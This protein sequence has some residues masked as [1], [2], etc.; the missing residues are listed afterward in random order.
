M[1]NSNRTRE[2]LLEVYRLAQT[3]RDEFARKV[4]E[5][6]GTAPATSGHIR[7]MW[8]QNRIQ[9]KNPLDKLLDH[10]LQATVVCDELNDVTWG[11]IDPDNPYPGLA[12]RMLSIPLAMPVERRV[13][14]LQRLAR[15]YPLYR[16]PATR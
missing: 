15:E 10:E 9:F 7:L 11:P 16:P 1:V 4:Q 12:R 3:Y 6:A 2:L 13:R 5:A 8:L 14:N